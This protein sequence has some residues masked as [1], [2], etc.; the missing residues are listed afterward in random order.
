MYEGLQTCMPSCV[1]VCEEEEAIIRMGR[2][3]KYIAFSQEKSKLYPQ[4]IYFFQDR[5]VGGVVGDG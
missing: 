4:R 5:M 1:C 3:R 2:V